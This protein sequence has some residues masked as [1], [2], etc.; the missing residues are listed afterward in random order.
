MARNFAHR[1]LPAVAALG[2]IFGELR[3]ERGRRHIVAP[4]HHAHA[5]L[6]PL[7]RDRI[8]LEPDTAERIRM[9]IDHMHQIEQIV[10][11]ELPIAFHRERL[12]IGAHR[13]GEAR[14]L[15][16]LPR[17]QKTIVALRRIA[18]PDPEEVPFLDERIGF[19]LR[20]RGNLLL[21]GNL[22]AVS[23]RIEFQAMIAAA[24]GIAF[25][26]AHRERQVAVAAAILERHGLAAFAAIEHHRLA[27]NGTRQRRLPD[28]AV[29]GRDVPA[30]A[31]KHWALPFAWRRDA[32]I[33]AAEKGYQ[34]GKIVA[35]VGSME[36]SVV[37]PAR[38]EAPNVT[39]LVGEIRTALDGRVDYE[40][41]YV[42]DGSSDA[43]ADAI[44]TL[45]R[46]FPRLRL[47][48]HAQSCGQSAAIHSG[49]AAA[50]APWIAT[51]DA[52]GQN[53]PADIPRLWGIACV[54]SAQEK[55]LIAGFR[56][57]RR[58]TV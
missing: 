19:D 52:D 41:I 12:A 39:P 36:L 13:A 28:L 11:V 26:L 1:R 57:K 4:A 27:Q 22:D 5:A 21:P 14:L 6:K 40:I 55:L 49:I 32:F 15:E 31:Q 2:I 16:A 25:A 58:D 45:M 23:G 53:D 3:Q 48:R 43:T 54:S 46:D 34:S 24:N 7:G 8:T 38:N 47:I 10:V 35:R 18:H 37:I 29:I 44:R 51:L 42:D 9:D 17:R 30:I 33:F 56:Q 20:A 50:R